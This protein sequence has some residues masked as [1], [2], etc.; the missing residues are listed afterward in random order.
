[1]GMDKKPLFSISSTQI[2][3]ISIFWYKSHFNYFS[4]VTHFGLI[5]LLLW[6][7]Y[8]V[9]NTNSPPKKTYFL[10]KLMFRVN[11]NFNYLPLSNNKTKFNFYENISF[12]GQNLHT[13]SFYNINKIRITRHQ[14]EW[15]FFAGDFYS[16]VL[17]SMIVDFIKSMIIW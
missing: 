7:L 9:H 10:K 4:K 13:N 6:Q 14:V 11:T 1:M 2:I 8:T 16:K 15:V 3:F 5:V 12:F 17:W